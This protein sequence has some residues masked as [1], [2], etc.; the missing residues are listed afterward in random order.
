MEDID[1][2]AT[3]MDLEVGEE[4]ESS[5]EPEDCDSED[6]DYFCWTCPEPNLLFVLKELNG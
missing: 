6:E 1:E 3:R 4:E 2:N 5:T